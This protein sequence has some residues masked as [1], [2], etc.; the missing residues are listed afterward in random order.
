MYNYPPPG[1]APGFA[2]PGWAPPNLVGTVKLGAML[3][4]GTLT[5]FALLS[6]TSELMAN[7]VHG[8]IGLWSMLFWV[9]ICGYIVMMV[10]V[11]MM[12]RLPRSFGVQLSAWIAFTFFL[13]GFCVAVYRR[14]YSYSLSPTTNEWISMI[15]FTGAYGS[16]VPLV[17]LAAQALGVRWGAATNAVVASLV[18]LWRT[19]DMVLAVA[20]PYDG[21]HPPSQHLAIGRLE[22]LAALPALATLA[23]LFF[24]LREAKDLPMFGPMPPPLA[25]PAGGYV[26]PPPHG[27]YGPPRY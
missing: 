26:P 5:G 22:T 7:L 18:G 14:V 16:L 20:F 1:M 10:G 6:A 8:A 21:H 15:T 12:S 13:V 25:P 3:V 24:E 19:S 2:P 11:V 27:G 17:M 4:F 9:R 23:T